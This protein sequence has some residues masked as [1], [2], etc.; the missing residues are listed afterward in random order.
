M[1]P[2]PA[3]YIGIMSGTSSDGIDVVLINTHPQISLLATHSK[4]ISTEL[5][6]EIHCLA[7]P[8]QS[9]TLDQLGELDH[10]LGHAFA[11]A[12][13]ELLHKTQTD[14]HQIAAIG[15]HGQTVRHRPSGK[16]PF[17]LQIG[18]PN[19][20]AARTGITTV[21]DFR[22]RDMATGGQGAP[23]VPGFHQAVFSSKNRD[24]A[25]VNIGGMANITWLP[26][27][28]LESGVIGF[29]TGPGNVLLDGWIHQHLQ[30]R[31]DHNGNWAAQG[32]LNKSLLDL[33]LTEDFFQQP[34]PKSTGRE[35][36]NLCWLKKQMEKLD[37]LISATDVQRTLLELTAKTIAD[38]IQRLSA[39][40]KEIFVCG[41]GVFNQLLMQRLQDL[42][43]PNNLASTAKLGIEPQWVEAMAFAWL[44]HQRME[45]QTGNI[46]AVT[47]AKTASVLG[48]IYFGN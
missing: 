16:F 41:G 35:M 38:S 22:R 18:D 13:M 36:F 7:D 4:S 39:D 44:A 26:Q 33:L 3:Y 40:H 48:A 14:P 1:N 34:P 47:G 17:T 10:K 19:I 15:S 5:Q 31:F 23:L 20:I 21:A 32:K 28:Q 8:T 2:K 27:S 6:K 29:D 45:N 11:D 46:C 12:V 42:L 24:R 43:S 37:Q 9:C 25:I 30:Q